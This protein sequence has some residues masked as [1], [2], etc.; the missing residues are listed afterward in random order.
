MFS[1]STFESEETVRTCSIGGTFKKMSPAIH[2]L[3]DEIGNV[4]L[5]V[6]DKSTLLK[7]FP[8]L[9]NEETKYKVNVFF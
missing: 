1:S 4:V 6:K 7:L 5:K 2:T 8:H 3:I 9:V